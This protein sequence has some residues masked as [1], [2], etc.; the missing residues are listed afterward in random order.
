MISWCSSFIVVYLYTAKKMRIFFVGS[1]FPLTAS[2]KRNFSISFWRR[3]LNKSDL[4][5]ADK[6]VELSTTNLIV[7][8]QSVC[9]TILTDRC[10]CF[11]WNSHAHTG[12]IIIVNDWSKWRRH[13]YSTD[14]MWHCNNA[15]VMYAVS[16]VGHDL[17]T[18]VHALVCVRRWCAP[19]AR[20]MHVHV[21]VET[22]HRPVGVH[23]R[24][25]SVYSSMPLWQCP[26]PWFQ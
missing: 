26:F 25:R 1:A 8:E 5:A 3:F 2:A 17:R 11:H 22:A 7:F 24:W 10:F 18:N 4:P 6:V 15:L 14:V 13:C 16:L 23:R 21:E 12:G 20:A 19:T 9:G